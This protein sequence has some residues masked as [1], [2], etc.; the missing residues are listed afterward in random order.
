[1]LNERRRYI[2]HLEEEGYA[3]NY[4]LVDLGLPSGL[5]WAKC[6]LGAN[7]PEKTGLYFCYRTYTSRDDGLPGVPLEDIINNNT[8]GY[9][10]K[11]EQGD[12]ATK[13]LGDDWT[14]PTLAQFTEL[15]N[16]TT[17]GTGANEKGWI[18][19][20][21]DTG[22]NGCLRKGP[23]GNEIFFPAT[24]DGGSIASREGVPNYTVTFNLQGFGTYGRYWGANNSGSYYQQLRFSETLLISSTYGIRGWF[25]YNVRAVRTK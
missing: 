14:T 7:K 3:P 23:N 25:L 13:Y 11:S 22:V 5:L 17:P 6:N 9:K 19:N 8:D 12:I 15:I 16:N 4:D 10:Y 20:Y 18:V 1:M 2:T 21:N 24:G